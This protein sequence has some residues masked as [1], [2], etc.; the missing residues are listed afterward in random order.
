MSLRSNSDDDPLRAMRWLGLLL[1]GAIGVFAGRLAA[2]GQD[3]GAGLMAVL[4]AWGGAAVYVAT[5]RQR[6]AASKLG[7]D[8]ILRWPFAFRWLL[9]TLFVG[10]V[11]G[12]MV[13]FGW[14]GR[15]RL[16]PDQIGPY[17]AALL[18]VVALWGLM[19]VASRVV[20]RAGPSG[21]ERRLPWP[22]R[23]VVLPWGSVIGLARTR[24]RRASALI[25]A[26][27]GKR[28]DLSEQLD[29]IG[30]F[31]AL[32]LANLPPPL[33]DAQPDLRARLEELARRAGAQ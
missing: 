32:L 21:I 2:H 29:G 23:A 12:A 16:R 30:D 11:L 8:V 25:V 3:R 31:A 28:I 5:R 10:P 20:F 9:P 6:H 19:M 18:A 22:G 4:A 14:R 26:G 7:G 1:F 15:G 24:R 27:R 17:C 33:I 13:A